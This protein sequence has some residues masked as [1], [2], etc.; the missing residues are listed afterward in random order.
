[1]LIRPAGIV[2]E[3]GQILT[4]RYQ[5]GGHDR[6]NLPGGGVESGEDIAS[7]LR[8]EFQEELKVGIGVGDLAWVAETA[9]QGR[10]VVHFLFHVTILEGRPEIDPKASKA[11]QLVWHPLES[12]SRIPLYPGMGYVIERSFL[13]KNYKSSRYLGRIEQLWY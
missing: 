6:F 12:L 3:N 13:N 10:E 2:V 1:M 11:L 4:M 9:V 5:F 7:A 8:R